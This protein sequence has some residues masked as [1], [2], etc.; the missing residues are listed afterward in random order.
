MGHLN[1]LRDWGHARDYVEMQWRMLQRESPSDYVIATGRKESVRKFIEIAAN[2]L[3]WNKD[4]NSSGILWE[5]EGIKEIG[6]RADTGK[7]VIRIDPRYFRPCEVEIL[8][9]DPSKASREL[10]WEAQTTLEELVYEMIQEDLSL[11]R[12]ELL[13]SKK[14]FNINYLKKKPPFKN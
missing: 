2:T 10:G 12:Q 6:R 5:G 4:T 8:L 11:A 1:S 13:I 3:G 7:I 14:G 9:G